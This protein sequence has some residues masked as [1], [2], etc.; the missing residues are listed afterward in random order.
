MVRAS[1]PEVRL[2][3]RGRR[4]SAGGPFSHG[5]EAASPTGMTRLSLLL[6]LALLLAACGGKEEAATNDS[7]ADVGLAQE[8]VI[9]ND[10]TAIDAATADDS[11]MAADT[12]PPLDGELGNG[13]GNTSNASKAEP[14]RSGSGSSSTRS[15]SG[16][17]SSAPAASDAPAAE[18]AAP[19]EGNAA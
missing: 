7:A 17:G 12:P 4:P 10:V 18:E 1:N 2:E 13:D 11:K 3:L 5:A 16:S 9:A 14:R 6:P 15:T 19:A 8:N